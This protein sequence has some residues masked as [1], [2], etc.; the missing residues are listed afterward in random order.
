MYQGM[1]HLCMQLHNGIWAWLM[2]PSK[3]VQ[4]AV[5]I[6]AEYV[7]KHLSKGYHLLRRAIAPNWMYPG[8]IMDPILW[9]FLEVR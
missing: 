9:N 8:N 6:C 5:R 4:K 7:A 1:K 3:Y 2:S